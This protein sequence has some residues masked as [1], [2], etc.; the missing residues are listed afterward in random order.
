[1]A[2]QFRGKQRLTH[3]CC[4]CCHHCWRL[5]TFDI[6][7]KSIKIEIVRAI[8]QTCN[9]PLKHETWWSIRSMSNGFIPPTPYP[10]QI[11][12]LLG[13]LFFLLMFASPLFKTWH[14]PPTPP[15]KLVPNNSM[16]TS[17]TCDLTLFSDN[18]TCMFSRLCEMR[19]WNSN[20]NVAMCWLVCAF[21]S[22]HP[23]P[24]TAWRICVFFLSALCVVCHYD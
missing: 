16:T 6:F 7:P 8:L 18:S 22:L 5:G 4:R 3:W 21:T 1:M 12:A 15:C 20:E 11:A 14:P 9:L 17:L 10:S 24:W 23:T 19:P 2:H 13:Q